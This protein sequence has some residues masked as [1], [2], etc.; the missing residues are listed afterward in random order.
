LQAKGTSNGPGSYVFLELTKYSSRIMLRFNL[1]PFDM[2]VINTDS[3][4]TFKVN[5]GG[6]EGRTNTERVRLPKE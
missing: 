2:I 5:H 6:R 3:R 4:F 1:P